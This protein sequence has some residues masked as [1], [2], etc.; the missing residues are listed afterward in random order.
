M[1][2]VLDEHDLPPNGTRFHPR[3]LSP[4]WKRERRRT[5]SRRLGS[6][7]ELYKI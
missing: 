7:G 3:P 1:H 4:N 6:A 2:V 5:S